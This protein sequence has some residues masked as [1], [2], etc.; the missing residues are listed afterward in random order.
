MWR[1]LYALWIRHEAD[2]RRQLGED[3]A[4]NMLREARRMLPRL[5]GRR[6]LA[7]T[8]RRAR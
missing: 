2:L 5:D 4:Q 8:L 3:Q 7:V 6:V 1:R